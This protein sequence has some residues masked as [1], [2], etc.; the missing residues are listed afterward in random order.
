MKIPTLI[1]EKNKD[2]YFLQFISDKFECCK[3]INGIK[4]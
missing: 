2:T 3:D 4:K 1:R